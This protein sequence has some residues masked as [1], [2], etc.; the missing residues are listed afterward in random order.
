MNSWVGK[1]LAA[2]AVTYPIH[3]QLRHG[4]RILLARETRLRGKHYCTQPDLV[5]TF[6]FL[7]F[8]VF[9]HGTSMGYLMFVVCLTSPNSDVRL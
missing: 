8:K 3:V 1:F 7:A 2:E 6:V 9:T 4:Q 5:G